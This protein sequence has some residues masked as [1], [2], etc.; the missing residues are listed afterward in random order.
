MK[1]CLH[2]KK[3]KP[4]RRPKPEPQLSWREKRDAERQR[5]HAPLTAGAQLAVAAGALLAA[6]HRK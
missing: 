2:Q 4:H 6:S 5:R 1:K 3:T